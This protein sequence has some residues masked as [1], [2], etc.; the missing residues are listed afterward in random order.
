MSALIS[1]QLDHVAALAAELAALSVTLSEEAPLCT[2]SAR[3]LSA[4]L[5]GRDGER[6]GDAGHGWAG[7]LGVLAERTDAVA[8]TLSRAVIAYREAD[9]A[10]A[11]RVG[12][13]PVG[14]T[15]IAR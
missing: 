3:S 10:L 7:L 2:S 4:A 15:A 1:V 9:T 5:G 13:G 14:A 12:P 8:T 11:Q 6:I